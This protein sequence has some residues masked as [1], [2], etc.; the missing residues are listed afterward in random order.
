MALG[1][2]AALSAVAAPRATAQT[3][4]A[5]RLPSYTA[6]LD[7]ALARAHADLASNADIWTDHSTWANPW[8]AK[9]KHYEVRTTQ[10]YAVTRSLAQGLEAMLKNFQTTLGI[11]FVPPERMK[12]F[13]FP[14]ILAYNAVGDTHAEHSSFY[15][16]FYANLHPEQPVAA[17]PHPNPLSL[18]MQITHSALHQDLALAFPGTHPVWIEEGLAAYFSTYWDYDWTLSEFERVKEGRTWVSL[19]NLLG[20]PLTQ[21][22]T[23]TH[24]RL[25]EL[26]MLFYYLLRYSEDT[27][28]T[29]PDE[30]EP[31]APFRDYLLGRLRGWNPTQL[32]SIFQTDANLLA[33]QKLIQA[34]DALEQDFRTYEFPR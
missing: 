15:G 19:D 26:G 8:S 12:V 9:T 14:D 5:Q 32:T 20:D 16:S 1:L 22:A 13:L 28:T 7:G 33:M 25:T 29:Q 18:R 27:R 4:A 2:A 30:A 23:R 24:E 31:R 10:T 11:D 34:T 21:Y 6:A 3:P 17:A